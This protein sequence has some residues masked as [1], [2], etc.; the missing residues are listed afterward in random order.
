MPRDDGFIG[1]SLMR[2]RLQHRS[3]H[4]IICLIIVARLCGGQDAT[5]QRFVKQETIRSQSVA[6]ALASEILTNEK[7]VWE[8]AKLRDMA[9]FAELVADDARMIFTSGVMTRQDYMQALAKRTITEYSI[10]NFQT[11]VP[12]EGMVIT[13]YEATMSGISNGRQ[14]SGSTMRESSVWV[15]RSSKWVAVWNQETPI[16]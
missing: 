7:A 4:L 1:V 8:A 13:L 14:F 9:R 15:Q 16:Q 6:P 12:A 3:S 2:T 10:K 5:N 11:F